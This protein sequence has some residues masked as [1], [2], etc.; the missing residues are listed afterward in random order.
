MVE[1]LTSGVDNGGVFKHTPINP[2]VVTDSV[3]ASYIQVKVTDNKGGVTT[4]NSV[5]LDFVYPFYYGT[6]SNG[7]VVDSALITGL[8]KDVSKKGAKSYNYTTS[9]SCM[10]IAF[11]KSYSNLASIIDPNGFNIT[12]SFIKQEVNVAANDSTTQVY[13]VYV[14]G[15]NTNSGFTVKFNF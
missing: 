9:N 10:V 13:N 7:A 8:T 4:A 15:A 2:V 12:D 14:S 11:P 3:S 6:V 5:A 1:N